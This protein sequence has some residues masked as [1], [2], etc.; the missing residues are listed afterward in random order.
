[1][2]FLPQRPPKEFDSHIG[3]TSLVGEDSEQMQRLGVIRLQCQDI[4]ITRVGFAAAPSLMMLD[5]GFQELNYARIVRWSSKRGIRAAL[6]AIHV[7][8]RLGKYLNMSELKER[9][10]MQTQQ[11]SG[12]SPKAT[13]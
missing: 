8:M 5:A 13:T 7:R 4:A 9:S 11:F 3:A 10:A 12:L 6:T 2:L 1:L